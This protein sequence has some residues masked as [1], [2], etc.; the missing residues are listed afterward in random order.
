MLKFL[1]L[2]HCRHHA[3]KF[4]E[5]LEC[6]V[7]SNNV[8]GDNYYYY[9]FIFY[10]RGRSFKGVLYRDVQLSVESFFAIA[11]ALVLHCDA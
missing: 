4:Q 10:K 7:P 8:S 2:I 3:V 5:P 6:H 1:G 11:I 9:L